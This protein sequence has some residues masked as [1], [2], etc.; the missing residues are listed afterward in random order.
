[1]ATIEA[2]ADK[3][4]EVVPDILL[5]PMLYPRAGERLARAIGPLPPDW[6]ANLLVTTPIFLNP[7]AG[8]ARDVAVALATFAL[9]MLADAAAAALHRP[10]PLA[11]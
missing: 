4:G 9:F 11:R 2:A 10:G 8:T 3:P 7:Q 6:P 5:E 1:M